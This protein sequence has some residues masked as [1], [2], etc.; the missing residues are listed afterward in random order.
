[1]SFDPI[2]K[3]NFWAVLA[4]LVALVAFLDAQG[5]TQLVAAQ[6]TL[7]AEQIASQGRPLGTAPAPPPARFHTTSAAAILGRNPFDSVTGPLTASPVELPSVAP[8]EDRAPGDP[9]AA[10]P[11]NDVKVLA[12]AAS[13]DPDWSLAAFEAGSDHKAILRR[14]G[15]E[16]GTKTVK[17]IGWDRVWLEGGS[18]LCQLPLFAP[19]TASTPSPPQRTV[20]APAPPAR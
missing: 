11:C 5:I 2:L 17:F 8:D 16:V 18:D 19:R 12:I 14:R 1:M 4:A 20:A 9:F 7:D 13:R 6:L 10:P 3:K 15:G